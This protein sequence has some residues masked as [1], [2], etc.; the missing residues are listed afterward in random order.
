[1]IELGC[2]DKVGMSQDRVGV[3]F[4][5]KIATF[6]CVPLFLVTPHLALH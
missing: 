5:Q 6:F 4:F 3:D 2:Q 1:M